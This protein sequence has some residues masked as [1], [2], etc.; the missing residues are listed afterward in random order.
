MKSIKLFS[1]LIS[2]FALA[3]FVI[4]CDNENNTGI[5]EPLSGE[6]LNYSTCKSSK[7]FAANSETPKT[8]SCVNYTYDAT[9]KTLNLN[10]INAGFNCCPDELSGK[11]SFNS[12]TILIEE[13]ETITNPCNCNCLYDLE[14]V[15]SGVERKTYNIKFIEPYVDEHEPIN[16]EI[17]LTKETSGSYCL[18]RNFYPWGNY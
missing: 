3:I 15:V 17:D 8:K 7:T 1:Y 16:F 10:H 12:D 9:S 6:L 11:I 18:T 5:Q 4:S 13:F 2:F 14:F